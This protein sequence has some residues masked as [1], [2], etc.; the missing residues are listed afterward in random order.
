MLYRIGNQP[1]K[2]RTISLAVTAAWL[3]AAAGDKVISSNKKNST[4]PTETNTLVVLLKFGGNAKLYPNQ[5]R[6]AKILTAEI[7]MGRLR[8]LF[9]IIIVL[10]MSL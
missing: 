9:T 10:L 4:N 8:K 1:S 3:A 6:L 7:K 2:D 5:K